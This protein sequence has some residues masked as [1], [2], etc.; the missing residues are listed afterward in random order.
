MKK[1]P[2]DGN[3]DYYN[4]AATS[5]KAKTDGGKGSLVGTTTN[6]VPDGQELKT[7]DFVVLAAD[8][9]RESAPIWRYL[10]YS[11]GLCSIVLMTERS[12][13]LKY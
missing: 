5:K 8:A 6:F 9:E 12:V 11:C 2:Y 1:R 10:S 4:Q 7:G 3:D 13:F